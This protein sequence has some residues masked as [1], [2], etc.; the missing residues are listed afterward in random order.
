MSISL[1]KAAAGLGAAT[2]ASG[3]GYLS[4]HYISGSDK[5]VS[6]F[7]LFKDQGGTLLDKDKDSDQWN[8]RWSEYLKGDKNV[9]NLKD[10]SSSK[11]T[12][13]TAPNSFKKKCISNAKE[14]VSG[15]K[16]SLYSEVVQYC[17]KE[18]SVSELI[19]Q[20][21]K[22][23]ALNT[24]SGEDSDWKAAWGVYLTDNGVNNPWGLANWD[25]VHKQ[26]DSLPPDFKNKCSE[27]AHEKVL[28]EVDYRFLRF[29]RWCSKSNN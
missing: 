5:K 11:G 17:A 9:W 25:S 13:S 8:A 29:S 1:A 7:Q 28:W 4:F 27:K 10:Y 22:F 12:P 14:K 15:V 16:D 2:G 21:P 26:K 24:S 19:N 18:F 20:N 3:L 23:T 6:V